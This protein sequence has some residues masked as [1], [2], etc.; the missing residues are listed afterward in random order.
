MI[1]GICQPRSSTKNSNDIG[2]MVGDAERMI[3]LNSWFS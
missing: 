1:F 3:F 2:V